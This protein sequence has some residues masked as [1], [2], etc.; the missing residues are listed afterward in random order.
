MRETLLVL[1]VVLVA[2]LAARCA[3][4]KV[5]FDDALKGKPGSGWEWL[6]EN[7]KAWRH[8]DRGLE[9]RV[10][11]G[12]ADTVKNALLRP[13]PDRSRGKYAIEVTV[14]FTAPPSQQ[15]EQAGLTWYRGGKPVFKLV[16]EY[17]DG[18]TY[19]I[20]G[21]KPTETRRVQLRLVVTREGYVAQFRPDAK[22]E[23]QTAAT[24]KLPPGA[25]E[26][27]SIQCYNG[28]PGKE[29]WMRFSDFKILKL[30]E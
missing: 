24:G 20:P 18:K 27:V 6:R 7:P 19:V 28:P 30:P 2:P 13:A 5:V 17:I 8:S 12:L 23:F 11:P 29:H 26:K 21:K 16:H 25:D 3:E 4:P 10:E 22:G 15:Y 1:S 14:E 9:I